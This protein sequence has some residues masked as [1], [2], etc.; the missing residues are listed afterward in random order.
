MKNYILITW[1]L[2]AGW[3]TSAQVENS[4]LKED[5]LIN[6]VHSFYDGLSKTGMESNY[7]WNKGFLALDQLEKWKDESPII[8]NFE[9][10]KLIYSAVQESD[11]YQQTSFP[12][13][14]ELTNENFL[15]FQ[16]VSTISLSVIN[17][18]GDY[19]TIAAIE[20]VVSNE[21]QPNYQSLNLFSG[22]VLQHKSYYRQVDFVW[23]PENYFS[24]K[25]KSQAL[26][27][28]FADG[29]GYR[30][31]PLHEEQVFTV[32]YDC[33]G[34]KSI[35]FK[36]IDEYGNVLVSYSK[37]DVLSVEQILPTK[38]G[39]VSENG[40]IENE[41]PLNK[42][43]SDPN[44]D[45]SDYNAEYLYFEGVDNK[46]DKPVII[47]EGFDFSGTTTP[48]TLFKEWNQ[49]SRVLDLLE[50]GYD[51]FFLS[52]VHHNRALPVN[53]QAVKA[54]IKGINEKKEGNYEGIFIGESTSG[55][56]GRIALKQLENE[57]YDHQI[58]LYV[59][60]DSPQ[61]GA[62][63]PIGAQWIVDD[64]FT[65]GSLINSLGVFT[66]F[67]EDIF[68]KDIPYTDIYNQLNCDAARQ[69]CA[70]HYMGNGKHN[71]IQEYL[72]S[73]G[74]PNNCRNIAYVDGS[75]NGMVATELYKNSDG[76][77]E[78][79]DIVLGAPL[80]AMWRVIPL[81]I[82]TVSTKVWTLDVNQSDQTVASYMKTS[83]FNVASSIFK[84][85][86]ESSGPKPW[87]SAPGSFVGEY[88]KRHAFTF[89]PTVSAIDLDRSIMNTGDFDYVNKN[90]AQ[91]VADGLT[92]FD[93]FYAN[94]KNFEHT[95]YEDFYATIDVQEY[96][97][98]R[99]Y[100]QNRNIVHNRDFEA[101]HTLTAGKNVQPVEFSNSI[102]SSLHKQIRE[103]KVILNPGTNVNFV[104]GETI[105]LN[106]GFEVES[107]ADFSAKIEQDPHLKMAKQNYAP[108]IEGDRNI[109]GATTYFAVKKG[110]NEVANWKLVGE[111]IEL[112]SSGSFFTTPQNL[113]S[114][115][116]T[117]F[118]DVNGVGTSKL[119]RT[120]SAKKCKAIQQVELVQP[121]TSKQIK[122][123]PNPVRGLVNIE[124]KE[125]ILD[126]ALVSSLGI[127]K[128]F[129]KNINLKKL[130]LD[131]TELPSGIYFIELHTVAGLETHSI[132]K[133]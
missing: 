39:F 79:R 130:S 117:L 30:M 107:G 15:N 32:N 65:S 18:T 16:G 42:S 4:N 40:L 45:L 84:L 8:T 88:H 53:A 91:I 93:D 127:Q 36:S 99:M 131:L 1:C 28:D 133:E 9:R 33:I 73:L 35:R 81:G 87:S 5:N 3:S 60:F 77:T 104:A 90:K 7:L 109:C 98:D 38:T 94:A 19:L 49:E 21:Q 13:L 54:L 108:K 122:V 132:I 37:V 24:N 58:G 115:Q 29:Q 113:V 110:N 105:T 14:E 119:L 61:A 67:F 83:I 82:I 56:L 66:D 111:G 50:H 126:Y 47:G 129:A 27:V 116:Y 89:V 2:L 95:T 25:P 114:G 23:N 72:G 52:Y 100:L 120:A 11:I 106:D 43:H 68:G 6:E 64:V 78:V 80:R 121:L 44:V 112:S 31:L 75:D 10:W 34:E 17:Y 55:L 71:D 70:R 22:T 26:L 76:H 118:C 59:S 123:F 57:H 86:K 102:N 103:E 12:P 63:I 124:S 97:Y 20:E 125:P 48:Y 46:L 128:K 74:Y 62:N 51:V 85:H 69:M 41:Q 101:Q 96:M 92:P